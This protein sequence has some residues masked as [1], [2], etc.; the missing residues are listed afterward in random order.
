MQ[1][2]MISFL[3]ANRPGFTFHGVDVVASVIAANQEHFASRPWA[4][5][6]H[7]E[8]W[9]LMGLLSRD[10]AVV[11]ALVEYGIHY[12]YINLHTLFSRVGG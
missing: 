4:T 3:H 12:Q 1:E 5:F 8:R 2:S 7:S 6:A 11:Q 9:L 10:A